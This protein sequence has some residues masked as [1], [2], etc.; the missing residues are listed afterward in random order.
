MPELAEVEFFQKQWSVGL[1]RK[2][3]A[4]HV[5]AGSRVLRD[6]RE[7]NLHGFLTGAYLRGSLARGKQLLFQFRG[8][9][10]TEGTSA[11]LGIHLGMTGKLFHQPLPFHRDK[12]DQLVLETG[13]HA[14]GFRDPRLFGKILFSTGEDYPA[15]WRQLAPDLCSRGFTREHML[16]FLKRRAKSP[17]KAVLMDQRRFPGIG[18]WMADEILWQSGIHPATPAGELAGDQL[19]RLYQKIKY[20]SRISLETIGVD[21][22]DPP[23]TWLFHHRWKPGG[24]CPKTG[25]PLAREKIGG[26]T[27]CYSPALQRGR[28]QLP[29]GAKAGAGQPTE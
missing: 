6:I 24:R 21:Y 22:R 17:V 7:M 15:F 27:T 20:V 5:R 25:V 1:N 11:W 16:A 29:P 13:K 8:G 9:P 18:N 28:G 12:H 4:V 10:L 26:R 3:N 2:I 19:H 23:R 14:L